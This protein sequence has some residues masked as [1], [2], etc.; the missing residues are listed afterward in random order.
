MVT[1]KENS[2]NREARFMLAY[3]DENSPTHGKQIESA[4]AAGYSAKGAK[5]AA[6]RVI[7]RY[8]RRGVEESLDLLG[9]TI[10]WLLAR[11]RQIIVNEDAKPG[12]RLAA[13]KLAMTS[14][15]LKTADSGQQTVNV[16]T[17]RALVVVGIEGKQLEAMTRPQAQL[18]EE[19]QNG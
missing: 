2:L 15:G 13:I 17:P 18:P 4:L 11:I 5:M 12:E 6:H 14:R 7:E 8:N 3:L 10:P 16:N 19:V 9:M 1:G